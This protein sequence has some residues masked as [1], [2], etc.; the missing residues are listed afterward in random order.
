M[1]PVTARAFKTAGSGELFS[2]L[3]QEPGR[4]RVEP[5]AA[6]LS[7]TVTVGPLAEMLVLVATPSTDDGEVPA[8]KARDP[9]DCPAGTG[10][11]PRGPT[12]RLTPPG[13]IQEDVGCAFLGLDDEQLRQA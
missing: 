7:F 5:V 11:T 9:V 2:F 10:P 6:I 8:E 4:P 13:W 3:G 1:P 12:G